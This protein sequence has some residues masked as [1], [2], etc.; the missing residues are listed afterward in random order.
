MRVLLL[1]ILHYLTLMKQPFLD[2]LDK[3]VRVY[4]I[5]GPSGSLRVIHGHNCLQLIYIFL[6]SEKLVKFRI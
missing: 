3:E 2:F 1:A 4:S 6:V 5:Y